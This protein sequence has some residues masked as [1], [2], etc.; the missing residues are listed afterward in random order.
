[1]V[2]LGPGVSV[3]MLTVAFEFVVFAFGG[4]TKAS[5]ASTAATTE[6]Q[7]LGL[8]DGITVR[9]DFSFRN[10]PQPI[11]SRL[12][13]RFVM[14]MDSCPHPT[15][16]I[17]ASPRVMEQ[18]KTWEIPL[19]EEQQGKKIQGSCTTPDRPDAASSTPGRASLKIH[20]KASIQ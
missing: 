11:H 19:V 17:R 14:Q 20:P 5:A 15:P 2:N 3:F 8:L 7:A 16:S 18:T 9:R 1:V 12:L 10:R 4:K 13:L 6:S